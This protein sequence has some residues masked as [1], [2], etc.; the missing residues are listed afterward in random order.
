MATGMRYQ[1]QGRALPD[2]RLGIKF[3]VNPALGTTDLIGGLRLTSSFNTASKSGAAA[4]TSRLFANASDYYDDGGRLR[5]VT[6]YSVLVFAD[7]ASLQGFAGLFARTTDTG[8]GNGLQVLQIEGSG[9]EIRV[10]ENNGNYVSSTG[11]V[12][13]KVFGAGLVACV[14]VWNAGRATLWVNGQKLHDSVGTVT[15]APGYSAGN[16]RIK[17]FSSRDVPGVTGQMYLTAFAPE[18]AWDDATQRALSI[19]PWQIFASPD[20]DDLYAAAAPAAVTG[21]LSSTLGPVTMAASGTATNR[22]VFASGLGG[23]SMSASGSVATLTPV[24]GAFASTLGSAVMSASGLT[25]NAG[26]FASA[27][28]GVTMAANGGV[29]TAPYG[30]FA[31]T[32]AG[33]SMTAAGIAIN[34]G[35]LS[36]LMADASMSATG[37]AAPHATGAYSSTLQGASMFA[38]GYLGNVAPADPVRHY[39]W[40]IL[41]RHFSNPGT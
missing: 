9:P 6:A 8:T 4:G 20:D 40:R 23:V 35:A 7:V 26:S 10:L 2:S 19:N 41:R 27:L 11:G 17:I 16:G 24:S 25:T 15:N 14:V 30:T 36:A 34:R 22:G 37:T 31:S 33:A 1:P 28:G 29:A 5:S 32:L 39:R 12:A 13:S 38:N 18:V 21:T 3:L